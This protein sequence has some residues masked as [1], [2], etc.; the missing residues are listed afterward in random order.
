MRAAG[1]GSALL[2]CPAGS[3]FKCKS[4]RLLF[5]QFPFWPVAGGSRGGRVS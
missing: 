2:T 4:L 3:G 1:R 5:C